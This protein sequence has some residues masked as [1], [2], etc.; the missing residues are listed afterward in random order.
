MNHTISCIRTNLA[1]LCVQS[2]A[3]H[4]YFEGSRRCI[5]NKSN[6]EYVKYEF[7][8]CRVTE[9]KGEIESLLFEVYLFYYL[10]ITKFENENTLYRD[11]SFPY[12]T[13]YRRY[14]NGVLKSKIQRN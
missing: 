13:Q 6:Y 12:S 4:L 5:L 11:A 10:R 1:N 2:D 8:E 9:G 7:K 14:F 3:N